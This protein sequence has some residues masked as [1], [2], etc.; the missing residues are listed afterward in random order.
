MTV[1]SLN[2]GMIHR[3]R[4]AIAVLA[5]WLRFRSKISVG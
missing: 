4:N 5:V 2:V 3:Y 1:E